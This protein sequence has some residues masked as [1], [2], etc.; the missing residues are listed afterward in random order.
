MAKPKSR[1]EVVAE[2]DSELRDALC[3]LG[4]EGFGLPLDEQPVL[5]FERIST[6]SLRLDKALGGGIPRGR[7]TEIFG[8]ESQGKS[9]ICYSIVGQ[10]Q[11]QGLQVAW[12]DSEQTFDGAWASKFGVNPERIWHTQ[13]DNGNQG[14]E[15]LRRYVESGVIGLAVVDSVTALVPKQTLAGEIGDGQMGAKARMMSQALEILTPAIAQKNV[16]VIFTNQLRMKIGIMFGNPE[17]TTGGEAL[18][19]YSSI[20][21]S[22]RRR[23]DWI[24]D[25]DTSVGMNIRVFAQKNKTAPPF[26]DAELRL[27]FDT[28]FDFYGDTLDMAVDSGIL[29]KSGAWYSYQG[30]RW[31]GRDN[32][33]EWFKAHPEAYLALQALLTGGNS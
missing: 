22:V 5:P 26:R 23:G 16:A 31:Q 8:P 27:M 17:T 4:G 11:Q 18:K 19:F 30:E 28:G 3:K 25:G 12:I 32:A 21:L 7:I 9:S 1:A 6:G 10:A 20:R 33:I 13:P 2:V 14:L 24:K 15:A 29:E